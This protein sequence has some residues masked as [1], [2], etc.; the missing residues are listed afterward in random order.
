M[1]KT[2]EAIWVEEPTEIVLVALKYSTTT[3]YENHIR[4]TS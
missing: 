1:N 3:H 2:V 4:F